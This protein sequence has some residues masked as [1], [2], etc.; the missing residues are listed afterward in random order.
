MAVSVDGD[1]NRMVPYLVADIRQALALADEQRSEGSRKSWKCIRR[2]LA[3]VSRRL[4]TF[5]RLLGSSCLP[6]R[7]AGVVKSHCSMTSLTTVGVP[8]GSPS[9]FAARPLVSLIEVPARLLEADRLVHAEGS[10]VLWG[11]KLIP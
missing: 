2:N 7:G 3:A 9:L 10:A 5:R 8:R 11:R 6:P 4:K 1:L